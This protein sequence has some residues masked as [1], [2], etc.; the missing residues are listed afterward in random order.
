[1]SGE[2]TVLLL[3]VNIPALTGKTA[4]AGGSSQPRR[5]WRERQ[6]S[7][8]LG[9]IDHCPFPSV[10]NGQI[11]SDRRRRRI[12]I[13][14]HSKCDDL[15]Y[16]MLLDGAIPVYL[17]GRDRFVRC[18]HKPGWAS[19]CQSTPT[20]STVQR[21]ETPLQTCEG[22]PSTTHGHTHAYHLTLNVDRQTSC[23]IASPVD[24]DSKPYNCAIAESLSVR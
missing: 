12:P 1:M 15:P 11:V 7:E 20:T 21:L 8:E 14:G 16:V 3:G 18:S 6:R 22:P 4:V 9:S 10:P 24:Q 23:A 19:P 5:V 2:P 13:W 17:T